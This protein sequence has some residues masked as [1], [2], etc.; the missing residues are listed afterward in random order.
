MGWTCPVC[1]ARI[2]EERRE[3]L[4]AALVTWTQKASGHCYLASFTTPHTADMEIGDTLDRFSKALKK[5]KQSPDYKAILSPKGSAGRIGSVKSL[6]TTWGQNGF[7]PHCH[8]LMFCRAG[9][10]GEGARDEGGSLHSEAIDRLKSK[11]VNCLLDAGLGERDK[12]TDMLKHALDIRGGKPSCHLSACSMPCRWRCLYRATPWAS[13]IATF[14]LAA[15]ILNQASRILT[16]SLNRPGEGRRKAVVLFSFVPGEASRRIARCALM[17]ARDTPIGRKC[18][19]Q[20]KELDVM[21]PKKKTG[22]VPDANQK[23]PPV[24]L[25]RLH[26]SQNSAPAASVKEKFWI[27]EEIPSKS[28]GKVIDR[29]IRK[30][31]TEMH[32]PPWMEQAEEWPE[33]TPERFV[34]LRKLMLQ[35][36][37]AQCAALL[38]VHVSTVWRWENGS[39]PIPFAAYMAL[40]LLLDVR[41]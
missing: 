18:W 20:P 28:W 35:L 2:A 14:R 32:L 8:E 39:I 3:E 16:T 12:L 5:F 40:R 7:H 10:F 13:S 19:R 30:G 38:R 24:V 17:S 36:K 21:T 27:L 9:A 34:E 37:A 33:I 6:E 4:T 41:Y 23:T 15:P 26:G 22:G 25:D 1:G 11:W 29:Y 31:R